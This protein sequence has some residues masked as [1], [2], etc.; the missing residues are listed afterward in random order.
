MGASRVQ[1]CRPGR[2]GSVLIA[3]A[4][5]AGPLALG[6]CSSGGAAGGPR[7]L[8]GRTVHPP[9]PAAQPAGTLPAPIL[10][11]EGA[12]ELLEMRAS[13][14]ESIDVEL[15]VNP[16]DRSLTISWSWTPETPEAHAWPVVQA[17]ATTSVPLSFRPTGARYL[18]EGKLAVAGRDRA[19]R[20]SI[21]EV[22]TLGVPALL[23]VGGEHQIQPGEVIS[24]R[25]AIAGEQGD[26]VGT[27]RVLWRNRALGGENIFAFSSEQKD[28][29]QIDLATGEVKLAATDGEPAGMLPSSELLKRSWPFHG[30]PYWHEVH[31]DMYA[32]TIEGDVIM[33]GDPTLHTL[34]FLDGDS[35]G[36]L[37]SFLPVTGVN[38]A[39]LRLDDANLWLDVWD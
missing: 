39:A 6:A 22:W 10:S 5:A 8:E 2:F 36:T 21:I 23:V 35:D 12:A 34:Y 14:G 13:T 24:R 27:L 38:E 31:G 32:L 1:R 16:L 11:S 37:D 19:K 7:G 17:L 26:A 30:G 28:L 15:A 18:G 4:G 25:L 3:L 9:A 33:E 29:F 20:E